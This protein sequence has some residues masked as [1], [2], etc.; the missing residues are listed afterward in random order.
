MLRTSDGRSEF[1]G[2]VPGEG[3]R[4]TASE[5]RLFFFF[6]P[7]FPLVA[8]L[9][10]S[11]FREN[12]FVSKERDINC[13]GQVSLLLVLAQGWGVG[14]KEGTR[15]VESALSRCPRC[16][17]LHS[18]GTSPPRQHGLTHPGIST[19][20]PPSLSLLDARGDTR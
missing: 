6:L 9:F 18:V 5:T 1:M 13:K 14:V 10:Q 3:H 16:R 8:P 4:P 19:S 20:P 12:H 2:G 7:Q 17:E 11:P 15:G